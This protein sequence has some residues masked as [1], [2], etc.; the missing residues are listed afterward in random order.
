[1][2]TE[3]LLDLKGAISLYPSFN[4]GIKTDVYTFETKYNFVLN[5]VSATLKRL[6]S[7]RS[8]SV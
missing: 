3:N 5:S 2:A 4:G 6:S 7:V 8:C 1:M